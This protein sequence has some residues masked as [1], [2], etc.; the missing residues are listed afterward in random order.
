MS[1]IQPSGILIAMKTKVVVNPSSN[2]RALRRELNTALHLLQ[3]NQFVL[4]VEYTHTPG[5][6]VNIAREAVDRG[7][8][9][10]IAVGGD[11]TANEII[12]GLFGS[13]VVLGL[14][15]IGAR[16]VL[17]RELEIPLIL[18]EA[19]RVI[20]RRSIRKMDLGC[21]GGRYFSMKAC[22]GFDAYT[23]Q[24][25]NLRVKKILRHY[26]YVLA[27]LKDLFGYKPSVIHIDIDNGKLCD[28][29]TFVIIS[30]THYYGG[31]F[32]V[33]PF[34]EIDD[35]FLDVCVYRG[36]TQIGLIGLYISV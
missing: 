14:F 29:G 30:N 15:P 35:G 23:V 3:K 34:A 5:Q 25:T 28:T 19:A 7:Y 22:C 13:R 32:Q 12:N 24:K 21:I 31:A 4:D 16:N 20:I 9:S 10:M 27:V 8:E 6:A 17:A 1:G 36:A 2:P 26:A 18:N 11:G 33:T